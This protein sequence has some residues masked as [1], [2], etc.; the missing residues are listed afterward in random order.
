M[1][2]NIKLPRRLQLL[3]VVWSLICCIWANLLHFSIVS[4]WK[5]SASRKQAASSAAESSDKAT[6]GFSLLSTLTKSFK[7]AGLAVIVWSWGYFG[8]SIGWVYVALFFH[9]MN[10]EYRKVKESKKAFAQH[11]LVD[12]KRAILSK[13]EE[14]PSWVC[15]NS[16]AA[17]VV[18]Q[19]TFCFIVGC[20][21]LGISHLVFSRLASI[22]IPVTQE[23]WL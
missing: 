17:S 21:M 8:F 4:I 2:F 18:F 12:E 6:S 16:Y 22:N 1:S 11:S 19:D 9:I 23:A 3:W 10:E 20:M 15:Y 5:M 14:Y 13:L 7:V